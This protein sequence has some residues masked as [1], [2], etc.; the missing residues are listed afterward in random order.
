V[1]KVWRDLPQADRTRIFDEVPEVHDA[2]E[3]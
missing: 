2:I 1:E 3:M